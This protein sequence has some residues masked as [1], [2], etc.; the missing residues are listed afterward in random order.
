MKKLFFV[1]LSL[2]LFGASLFAQEPLKVRADAFPPKDENNDVKATINMA[3][4]VADMANWNRYPTYE[5]Y[6][7]MMQGWAEEFP[8]LCH[9][10]TIGVSVNGRQILSMYIEVQTVVDLYRPEFFYSSTMHGDEVTGFVMM[11]RLIDTLLHG[12]G[13]NEQYTELINH[14][15]ISIN[16]LSNPDGTYRSGNHTVRNAMRYN[17]NFVDLN[18]NYPDP[19]GTEPMQSQQPENT[20]II[21]YVTNHNFRLSANLHGGAEVMN[22]PWDSFTSNEQPHPKRDWWISV[23]QRFIDTSRSYSNSHF[24][25]TYP[26]GYTAGGDWYVI[27]NG[28]QD[29][30]NHYHNCLE[31]TMEISSDK[32]LNS[33][34]LP[35][36]WRF[37]QHPLVNYIEEIHNIDN[38]SAIEEVTSLPAS[39]QIAIY[40][41]PSK[42]KIFIREELTNQIELFDIKGIRLMQL[43]AGSRLV[44]LQG[45]PQ[46]IYFLRSGNR[47][48]KIV[49]R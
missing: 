48:G 4:T 42:D 30:M 28:R 23:C 12:Y 6:I 19:F 27:S 18:R 43:P 47:T 3:S 41:N 17:A 20:A 13:S 32:T 31:M 45:L 21:N 26:S 22:Y 46:G 34:L 1:S 44:D 24:R 39:T 49:K 37:L 2:L 5:T 8:T 25:D 7:A 15:R 35:E 36:Y 9:L 40:P 33:D 29:Y 38:S 14:T 11:L 16:P 10:D